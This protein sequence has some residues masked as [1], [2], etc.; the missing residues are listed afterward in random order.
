[1]LSCF[2]TP[3]GLW[4][5]RIIFHGTPLFS[6]AMNQGKMLIIWSV[7]IITK[8]TSN[9]KLQQLL[10][11]LT[12][13]VYENDHVQNKCPAKAKKN[14]LELSQSISAHLHKGLL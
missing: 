13:K 9:Q 8:Y 6:L 11:S 2:L 7:V 12:E 14:N 3:L 1:M 5:T 10:G 4:V